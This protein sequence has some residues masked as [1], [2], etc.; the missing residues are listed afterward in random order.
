MK[1]MEIIR[2]H[3]ARMRASCIAALALVVLAAIAAFELPRAGAAL[4][5]P[6]VITIAAV[7]AC[8]WLGFSANRDAARRLDAI[9]RAFA[10]HGD[11]RRLL[12]DH[13]WVYLV[14]LLRLEIMVACGLVVAV[15]GLGA[16][17][18]VLLVLLG[19]I[20]IALTWP[21]SRKARL[22]LGRARALR[23]VS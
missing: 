6:Q 16:R 21:T 14:V 2:P 1:D 23:D 10:A 22:L 9:R 8:L 19:G 18:G 7:A 5:P 15:W 20:V 3:L 11:E 13:W 17:L 4:A 12:R